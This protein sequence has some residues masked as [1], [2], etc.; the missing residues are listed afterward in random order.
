[1]MTQITAKTNPL[2]H[3][4]NGPITIQKPCLLIADHTGPLP[5]L[6]TTRRAYPATT[7]PLLSRLTLWLTSKAAKSFPTILYPRSCSTVASASHSTHVATRQTADTPMLPTSA[8][9]LHSITLPIAG[10]LRAPTLLTP[11]LQDPDRRTFLPL[12]FP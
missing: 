12:R 5:W 6:C 3:P 7:P 11:G 2:P 1:M 4:S 10:T 9:P 8:L